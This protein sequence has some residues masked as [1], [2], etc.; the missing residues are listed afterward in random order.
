MGHTTGA[1]SS[2]SFVHIM[3]LGMDARERNLFESYL[4]IIEGHDE[5]QLKVTD[6]IEQAD[7]L[8]F[9]R[10]T[11]PQPDHETASQVR[12]LVPYGQPPDPGAAPPTALA[13]PLRFTELRTLIHSLGNRATSSPRQGNHPIAPGLYPLLR[14]ADRDVPLAIRLDRHSV[15]TDPARGRC[16]L[17]DGLQDP[18]PLYAATPDR[19]AIE[20][21]SDAA[22]QAA[23]A[24]GKPVPLLRLWWQAA[25]AAHPGA[26]PDG[27]TPDTPVALRRWP[28]L[29]AVGHQPHYAALCARITRSALAPAELAR[30]SGI[31]A[32]TVADFLRASAFCGYLETHPAADTPSAPATEPAPAKPAAQPNLIARIKKRL[33]LG[34]TTAPPP[35]T[36][37][38]TTPD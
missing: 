14:K 11:H 19:L 24:S 35:T 17:P 28:D 16:Y 1:G 31:H 29:G 21:A 15:V 25:L 38:R 34:T 5:I 37:T 27:V 33:G 9:D 22:L 26:L 2:A 36:K 3:L 10:D 8:V 6:R 4:G 30:Q 18:T 32:D 7:L 23:A 12:M 13:K 20:P